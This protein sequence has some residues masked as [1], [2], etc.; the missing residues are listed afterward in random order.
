MLTRSEISSMAHALSVMGP[1]GGHFWRV[2]H[3]TK[4]GWEI[5]LPLT[6]GKLVRAA[7]L[8]EEPTYQDALE[9]VQAA[10]RRH[11]GWISMAQVSD[12]I[13]GLSTMVLALETSRRYAP[14]GGPGEPGRSPP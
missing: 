4:G 6:G 12:L 8:P 14:S 2:R 1:V 9:A 3:N 13:T 10:I 11:P 5:R 7:T